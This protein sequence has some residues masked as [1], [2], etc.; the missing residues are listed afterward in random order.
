MVAVAPNSMM[1]VWSVSMIAGPVGQE[2]L[3]WSLHTP[4]AAPPSAPSTMEGD[5]Q[6]LTGSQIPALNAQGLEPM[7]NGGTQGTL[8]AAGACV[9]LRAK[10]LRPKNNGKPGNSIQNLWRKYGHK[11]L[12][13]VADSPFPP[14]HRTY[15]KC[16]YGG[17]CTSRLKVD[18]ERESGTPINVRAYGTHNHPLNFV[19]TTV[20]SVAR[21]PP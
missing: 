8:M 2:R 15:Y 6:S 4:R 9:D 16:G 10:I 7:P 20:Q 14:C 18:A 5:Q 19:Q 12:L 1:S 13:H 3:L 11:D 17:G 21:P